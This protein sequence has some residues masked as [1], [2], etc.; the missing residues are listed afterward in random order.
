MPYAS[1]LARHFCALMRLLFHETTHCALRNAGTTPHYDD[2]DEQLLTPER[3][4]SSV[5][6]DGCELTGG[7]QAAQHSGDDTPVRSGLVCITSLPKAQWWLGLRRAN[8]D[9]TFADCKRHREVSHS[10]LSLEDWV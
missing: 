3:L 1:M 5:V 4:F 9:A 7:G 8:W 2:F 10:I 6:C